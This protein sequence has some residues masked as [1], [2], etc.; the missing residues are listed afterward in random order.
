MVVKKAIVATAPSRAVEVGRITE[1]GGKS[2]LINLQGMGM[3]WL[4][5]NGAAGSTPF[6]A[7]SGA[8]GRGG[9][10][11]PVANGTGGAFP[12]L[13]CQTSKCWISV[14]PI[15]EMIRSTSML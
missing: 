1:Q 12:A 11:A 10:S 3:I 4:V 5:S 14:P 15:A 2:E 8:M 6:G 9:K 7:W 13:S